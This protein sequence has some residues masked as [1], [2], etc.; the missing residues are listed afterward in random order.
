MGDTGGNIVEGFLIV[1]AIFVI[2]PLLG[3]VFYSTLK[4]KQ[5][6]RK[7]VLIIVTGI[8]LLP[9][10]LIFSV[11][12]YDLIKAFIEVKIHRMQDEQRAKQNDLK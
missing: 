2:T 9:F 11:L 10:L 4:A 5:T 6:K 12:S 3:L 1:G 8:I 7:P